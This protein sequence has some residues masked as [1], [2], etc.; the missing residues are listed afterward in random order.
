VGAIMQTKPLHV[1]PLKLSQPM[2]ATLAFLGVDGC[3][4]LMHGA[5]GCASFTKVFFTRHFQD[6][7]AIQTTAVT[8]ITAV[9]DGGAKGITEAVENITKKVNPALIGLFTTGLTETKGDDIKGA[10]S[11]LSLPVVYVNTPDYEGAL[12]SG[13][14]LS[15]S[16]MI[17]QLTKP[18]QH[19]QKGKVA[20]LPHVGMSALELER[21]KECIA[22][23]GLSVV[24]LPDISLSLD[25]HLGE[26]QTALS[27]GGTTVEEIKELATCE[28]LITVGASMEGCAKALRAKNPAI[29]PLH[30][31]HLGGLVATD[32]FIATLMALSGKTPTSAI[33]RWRARLQDALLD[34]HELL[35][36]KNVALIGEP[37]E[38]AGYGA[39]LQEAGAKLA[40]VIGASASAN[41]ENFGGVVGDFED[42]EHRMEGVDVVVGNFH[43]K[44]IAKRFGVPLVVRGFPSWGTVGAPLCNSV[45]YEGGAQ[46]LFCVANLCEKDH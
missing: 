38:I 9:L 18:A 1:N 6:P 33:K 14:A 31:N 32:S 11:G 17:S 35:G 26:K 43:A 45:L 2:G 37:D 4:P 40:C 15:V 19:T 16:A 8:D 25:G 5:Q 12:E 7:I 30:V 39:L 23:F 22:S 3:M 13:W 20:L 10:A 29:T 42:L 24:A 21:L 28:A 46:S 44:A 36:G 41:L 27:S 34:T